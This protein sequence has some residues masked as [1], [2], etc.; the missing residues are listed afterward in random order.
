VNRIRVLIFDMGGTLYCPTLDHTVLW[1]YFLKEVG[2]VKPDELTLSEIEAALVGPDKWLTEYMIE[3]N[4]E[5]HWEP[6]FEIWVEYVGRLFNELNLERNP[7]ELV[8]YQQ[9]HLLD[10]LDHFGNKIT[11]DCRHVLQEIDSRGYLIGLAS[12]RFGDPRP[13]LKRSRILEYFDAIEYTNVPGYKKPSPFMLLRVAEELD[14]NP[15]V[16]AFIGDK[17][18]SDVTAARYAEMSPILIVQCGASETRKIPD[19]VMKINTLSNLLDI[20]E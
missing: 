6:D 8:E 16:C 9:S 10:A 3:N 17:I 1:K 4:I 5:P 12:N 20:F 2:I 18:Q 15:R 7:I 14:V 11:E 19:D 13:H